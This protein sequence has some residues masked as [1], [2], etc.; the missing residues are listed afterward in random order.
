[1]IVHISRITVL[2]VN[3]EF[4]LRLR[5]LLLFHFDILTAVRHCCLRVLIEETQRS[6]KRE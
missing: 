1:M 2:H 4:A 5:F 3:G 6:A